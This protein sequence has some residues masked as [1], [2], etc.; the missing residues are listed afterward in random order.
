MSDYK[1][2]PK[3]LL[4]VLSD[5]SHEEIGRFILSSVIKMNEGSFK[6]NWSSKVRG[7]NKKDIGEY[8]DEFLTFWK[9]YPKKSGKIA[10]FGVW[11]EL[12]DDNKNI[13]EECL[14]ALEWQCEQEGWSPSNR[15]FTP[16]AETYLRKKRFKDEREIEEVT[17][18]AKAY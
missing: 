3:I 13:L 6:S 18:I 17:H 14:S 8:T 16:N 9:R 11:C 10:A 12:Y 15:K 2:K 4:N 7:K 1:I 5:M